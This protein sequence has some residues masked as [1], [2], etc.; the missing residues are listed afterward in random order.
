MQQLPILKWAKNNG[1]N[2]EPWLFD[3]AIKNKQLDILKWA[4][5]Y[6]Y[7]DDNIYKQAILNNYKF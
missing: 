2:I 6:N 1:Y 3:D 7:I 5:K 4:Y